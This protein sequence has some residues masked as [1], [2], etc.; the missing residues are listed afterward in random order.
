MID[1]EGRGNDGVATAGS[2]T[3]VLR[4]PA[5]RAHSSF[6]SDGLYSRL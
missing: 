3:S 2:G 1:S 5:W 6:P 4:V